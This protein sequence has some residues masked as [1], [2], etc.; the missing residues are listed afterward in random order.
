MTSP[1]SSGDRDRQEPLGSRPDYQHVLDVA[2][3]YS[4]PCSDPI[5]VDAC[6]TGSL[7]REKTQGQPSPADAE[8]A[9]PL[10]ST[11]TAQVLERPPR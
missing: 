7:K 1:D 3:E 9:A 5:A 8:V 11:E 2:C 10:E 4:F 6:C